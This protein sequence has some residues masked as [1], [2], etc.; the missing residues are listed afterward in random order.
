MSGTL[1]F[2]QTAWEWEKL[3]EGK[4][5]LHPKKGN[6]FRVNKSFPNG[7]LQLW[8]GKF[9]NNFIMVDL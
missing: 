5:S 6:S 9:C 7:S 8:A 2:N 4:K 3:L 1:S